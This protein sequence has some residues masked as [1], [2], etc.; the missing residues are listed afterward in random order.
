MGNA[1]VAPSRDPRL[2]ISGRSG[3]G[4]RYRF[5]GIEYASRSR[6]R[7]LSVESPRSPCGRHRHSRTAAPEFVLR[8]HRAFVR[9]APR[10]IM[11]VWWGLGPVLG[12]I[13]EP[14]AACDGPSSAARKV[15]RTYYNEFPGRLHAELAAA[16]RAGIAAARV[17][18]AD[19]DAFAAEGERM[20]YVLAGETLLV[21]PRFARGEE[22]THGALANG[23]PVQA[24][25]ELEVVQFG[26]VTTV[27]HLDNKSGHYLPDS[28]SLIVAEEAFEARGLRVNRHGVHLHGQDAP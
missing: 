27:I 15:P 7:P 8:L 26:G 11:A 16:E 22:M 28:E 4:D 6:A 18:S 23:G 17:P 10:A 25:G 12:G 20:I 2:H 5:T 24:A 13:T 9:R 14:A 1:V 21:A 19:F 3:R